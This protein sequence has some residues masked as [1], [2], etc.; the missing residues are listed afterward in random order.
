MEFRTWGGR[1]KGAGRK[2]VGRKAGI[3]HRRRA[4]LSSHHPVHITLRLD[5]AYRNLR[6]KQ[7]FKVIRQ[8]FAGAQREGY[9]I[10]DWS[11]QRDHIHL[12]AE[13]K[14]AGHL[15]RGM[16]GFAIRVAKG[17]NKLS[18]R[19]G[20]VFPDRYHT[21]VLKTPRE[22]RNALCYVLNNGRKHGVW[23][24]TTKPDVYTSA[25]WFEGWFDG[26]REKRLVESTR[27]ENEEGEGPRPTALPH[28]WLRKVG[29][30]RHS[31]IRIAEVPGCRA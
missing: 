25:M 24:P 11:V 18:G 21:H 4:P 29:W 12:I 16:R 1:R 10:T 30:R 3:A 19:K 2:P 17:L 9:R 26:W 5:R 22:V 7:R 28:T 6:T 31:L 13:A 23:G 15:S 20:S 8:A 14:D 27:A